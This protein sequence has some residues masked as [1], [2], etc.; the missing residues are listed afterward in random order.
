MEEKDI[1]AKSNGKNVLKSEQHS[2]AVGHFGYDR[3]LELIS[4]NFF[5][6]KM[7]DN[8]RQ[9]CNA[10]NNCQR[11]DAPRHATHRLLHPSELPCKTYTYIS[12]D[13]ITNLPES[14][15]CLKIVVVVDRFT[16]MANFIPIS[17]KDSP[18]VAEAYLE[19]VW[20]YQGFPEDL[21]SDR[22]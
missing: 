1:H 9:C 14:S 6:S 16:Q 19:N 11:T 12:T 4:Q 8:V 3:T 18:S 15:G 21:G 5:L 2:K 22:N 20:K 10:C 17:N 13:F 7:V